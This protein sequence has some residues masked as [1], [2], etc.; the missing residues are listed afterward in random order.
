MNAFEMYFWFLDVAL[1]NWIPG[2]IALFGILHSIAWEVTFGLDTR[3]EGTF[4]NIER[5]G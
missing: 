4:R 2:S 1:W 3:R 5:A